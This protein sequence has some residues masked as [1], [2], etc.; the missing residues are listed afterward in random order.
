MKRGDWRLLS[1][2]RANSTLTFPHP[3]PSFH[4]QHFLCFHLLRV[5]LLAQSNHSCFTFRPS[6]QGVQLQTLYTRQVSSNFRGETGCLAQAFNTFQNSVP[7]PSISI[8]SASPSQTWF[9]GNASS[10]AKVEACCVPMTSC[11]EL[12]KKP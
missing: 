6:R 8:T 1:T 9:A 10:I 12:P 11:T 5:T 2:N 3:C 7:S 4:F